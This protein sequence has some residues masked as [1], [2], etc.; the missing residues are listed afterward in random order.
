MHCTHNVLRRLSGERD[1][2]K[3][4]CF[5][6]IGIDTNVGIWLT[7]FWTWEDCT[8]MIPARR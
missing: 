4:A 2:R 1:D 7:E 3:L 6:V 5:K 8:M